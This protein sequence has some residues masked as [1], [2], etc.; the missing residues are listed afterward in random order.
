M[1]KRFLVRGMTDSNAKLLLRSLILNGDA[2]RLVIDA[3]KR[4]CPED[5]D[6]DEWIDGLLTDICEYHRSF[7]PRM[8]LR[9]HRNVQY[10]RD[11]YDK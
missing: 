9:Q 10:W 6:P 2:L 3:I 4:T 5:Q 7:K 11:R 8:I 1:V